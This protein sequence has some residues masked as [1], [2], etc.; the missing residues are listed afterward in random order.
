MKVLALETSKDAQAAEILKLKTRIKKLEKKCKPSISHHK[1]WLRSVSRLS[2]T[3][4]LG[5]KESISKQGREN[6]KPRPTLDAFDDL[7]ADLAHG[8]DYMETEKAVKEGRQSNETK[9]LNLDVDTEVIAKD[10]GSGENGV[11][12]VSTAKPDIDTTRPEVHTANAPVSTVGV[13]IS[14]VDPEM[15]EEKPK[16]KGVAFKDVEDSSRPVRL[17]TTL[18]P[19]PFINPK[20][21]GKGVLE[22]P[23]PAKKMTRS[24]FDVAQV[25]R[26]AEVARQLE[27]ELQAEEKYTVD[28]R[29]K[30]LAEF[31]ERR[32]NQ[33]AEERDDAIRNKP[34]TRT[35]L[36]SLMLTY[37]KHT[38]GVHVEEVL[39]EPNST[40]VKV[41]LEEAEQGTKKTPGKIVKMKARMKA[42]KQ[43]H[44]DTDNEHDSEEDERKIESMNKE[45]A[46][47][48]NE[49]V[50]N[51]SKKRKGGPRMKR[52]SK[53]KKTN[54]DLEE[55][56]HLKTFLKI[57]PD[58]E[59]IIDFEV[60]IFRSDGSSRWIKTFSEMVTRFDR[61]DLVELYNLNC[62][63]HTL[64]LEDGNEIHMLAERKYP[65]TKETLERILSL[66]LIAESASDS[67]Y[68][69]LR[70][71][72]K[73]IDE[74]RSHDGGEK[75]L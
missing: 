10:K 33:L 44:A 73:Q 7:D 4:K 74:A 8:M 65:L 63:V 5:K 40:K 18:K 70:F 71:I 42:R 16:E 9:E 29:A 22:E 27:V 17:I 24:D 62:G 43:T 19:L 68:D 45:D 37:L 23:E 3:K 12:T 35:Q 39:K 55:E 46:G 56:G 25:A 48:S 6:A 14:T 36:R 41:K 30:L 34:P 59:G 51:V 38:A 54:S 49:K 53:R 31:F 72:Q 60:R 64:T 75:D 32:K 1:A 69:L 2:R 21:K 20:D 58:E 67:A 47:E 50:S 13:T 11:S 26:D 57:V 61:L 15:K 66:K 28:E 52:H